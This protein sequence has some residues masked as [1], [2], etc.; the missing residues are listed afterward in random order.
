MPTLDLGL[1]KGPQGEQGPAGPQGP[2]G[3]AGAA[4]ATGPVGP[5]GPQGERGPAGPQGAV[6]AQ[7]GQGPKGDKGDKGDTGATGPQGPKGATGATG[8]T[9]PRGPGSNPNL[10]VNWYFSAPINQRGQ[11]TYIGNEIYTVDRWRVYNSSSTGKVQ[12]TAS[13]VTVSNSSGTSEV[14]FYQDLDTDASKLS[15]NMTLSAMV[16]DHLITVTF[17]MPPYG[18]SCSKNTDDNNGFISF[19]NAFGRLTVMFGVKNGASKTIQA[20]K[21]EFGDQQTLA[22]QDASGNWVLNDPPPNKALELAKCQRYYQRYGPD[23][24]VCAIFTAISNTNNTV[25]IPTP[26]TMR[27]NPAVSIKGTCNIYLHDGTVES[28]DWAYSGSGMLSDNGVTVHGVRF[29]D[30]INTPTGGF[31]SVNNNST[32][33]LNSDL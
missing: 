16:D 18:Y 7:G 1:V 2:T 33:E 17:S 9:G 11:T 4:G 31:L 20:I 21:L 3:P 5:A 6:G 13:G 14:Q 29:G 24:G 15:A 27:A 10:L 30:L 22:H 28:T 25:Y 19:R 32:A 26:V 23:S 8:A 12:V